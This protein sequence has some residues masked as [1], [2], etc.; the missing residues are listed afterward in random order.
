MIYQSEFDEA[1]L[2][3]RIEETYVQFALRQR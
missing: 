3:K 2:N 1:Y